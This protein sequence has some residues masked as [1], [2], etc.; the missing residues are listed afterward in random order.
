MFDNQLQYCTS[1]HTKV[2]RF[3]QSVDG[4]DEVATRSS[5]GINLASSRSSTFVRPW[6]WPSPKRHQANKIKAKI[7]EREA[8]IKTEKTRV[9]E[10]DDTAMD[11]GVVSMI[12]SVVMSNNAIS[13]YVTQQQH[14]HRRHEQQV[15]EESTEMTRNSHRLAQFAP[16]NRNLNPKAILLMN[17]WFEK[18]LDNPYPSRECIENLALEGGRVRSHTSCEA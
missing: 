18:N 3:N 10:A 8:D 2:S 14:H 1:A 7:F 4:T 12:Q 17:A 6:E 5:S 11:A 13:R 15:R 9:R 16:R